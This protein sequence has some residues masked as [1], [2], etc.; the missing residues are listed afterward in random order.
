[1]L[2]LDPT[3]LFYWTLS[4]PP[5]EKT[6][7]SIDSWLKNVQSKKLASRSMSQTNSVKTGVTGRTSAKPYGST[8]ASTAGARSAPALTSA[9]VSSRS[10]SSVLTNAITIT[11]AQ[12]PLAVKVK[13]DTDATIYTYDGA[14]SDHEETAGLE[15]DAA[16]ASPVKGKRRLNSEVSTFLIA[17]LNNTSSQPELN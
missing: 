5:P 16:I 7:Y 6:K 10:T 17:I 15:R 3:T 11:N 13:Q 1:M 2:T 4:D 12:V 14:L 9:G 8:A